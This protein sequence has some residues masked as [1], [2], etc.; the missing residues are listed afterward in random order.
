MTITPRHNP[1]ERGRGLYRRLVGTLNSPLSHKEIARTT[2][3]RSSG[4]VIRGPLTKEYLREPQNLGV[5]Q[6][7]S[8]VTSR[9]SMASQAVSHLLPIR[10]LPRSPPASQPNTAVKYGFFSTIYL[11]RID[12]S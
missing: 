6:N 7:N 9:W 3:G 5:E 1:I 12:H 8:W 11:G 4:R 10:I 2:A